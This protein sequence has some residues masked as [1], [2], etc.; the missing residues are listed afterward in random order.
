MAAKLTGIRGISF[1]KPLGGVIPL[2]PLRNC[3]RS[4]LRANGHGEQRVLLLM[5]AD[6]LIRMPRLSKRC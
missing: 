4:L 6:H 3:G 5:P 1:L 2:R